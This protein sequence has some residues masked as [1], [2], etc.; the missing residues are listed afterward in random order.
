MSAIEIYGLTHPITEEV[1]YV[2]KSADIHK[3]YSQHIY[4]ANKDTASTHLHKWIKGLLN[5]GLKPGII[6]LE[7]VDEDNWRERERY[8]IA[9]LWS[10]KSM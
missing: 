8:W 4:S 3:R 10:Q 7:E 2:G 1:K 6:V 5:Q 9:L